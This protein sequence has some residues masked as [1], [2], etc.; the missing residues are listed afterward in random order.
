MSAKKVQEIPGPTPGQAEVPDRPLSTE[1][2]IF[3]QL[4]KLGERTENLTKTVDSISGRVDKLS[5]KVDANH[6][7]LSEKIGASH[8]ELSNRVTSIETMISSTKLLI[9]AFGIAIPLVISA[10]W[11]LLGPRITEVLGIGVHKA[12][13]EQSSIERTTPH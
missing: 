12:S 13:V 6:K 11:A 5:E 2:T 7:E 1:T 9:V 3:M 4:S 8:K 10:S